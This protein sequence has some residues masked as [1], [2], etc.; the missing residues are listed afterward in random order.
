ML[1]QELMKAVP[2]VRAIGMVVAPKSI[3]GTPFLGRFGMVTLNV[4]NY[5]RKWL[6]IIS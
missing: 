3:L 1:F 4:L 2:K 5:F 6:P